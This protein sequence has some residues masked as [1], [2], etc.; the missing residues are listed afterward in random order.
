M[1]GNRKKSSDK[2]LLPPDVIRQRRRRLL[3]IRD[4]KSFFLHLLLIGLTV[5]CL[6]F[7]FFGIRQ[8]QNNDMSPRVSA[9][10]IIIFYRKDTEWRSQDIVLYRSEGKSYLGRIIA[11]GGDTVEI[12]EE[13][14]IFINGSISIEN[15]IFYATR[16]YESS[17]RYPLRL[18][19]HEVFILADYREGAKDSRYFGAVGIDDLE[20]KVLTLIRRSNL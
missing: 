20:G 13:G 18:G 5:W 15:D 1:W 17:V 16:P 2:A 14:Q 12:T 3:N 19:E 4:V 10:D 8:V 9:G 7:V 6:F 11:V